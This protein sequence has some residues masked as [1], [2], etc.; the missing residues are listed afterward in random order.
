MKKKLGLLFILISIGA[1][2]ACSSIQFEPVTIDGFTISSATQHFIDQGIYDFDSIELATLL[3]D[4]NRE[5]P[6]QDFAF[7]LELV[8]VN[9][10]DETLAETDI[11]LPQ[12]DSIVITTAGTATFAPITFYNAGSYTFRI[13]QVQANIDAHWNTDITTFYL[14]VTV[15]EDEENNVLYAR[16]SQPEV[17]EF[18]N[19]FTLYVEE[20]LT[21]LFN[22]IPFRMSS[23]YALLINLSTGEV[24]FDYQADVRTYPASVTK[25]MTVLVGLAHGQMD[26]EVTVQADF[27]QLW[28]SQSAQAG[29]TYGET[30][31]F[32]EIIHGVMLMSGGEATETLAKHIAGSYEAF[33]DLMNLKAIELG[34]LDT[35]FVTATG[36]HDENHFT[37]AN[38]IAILLKYALEIPEFREMFILEEYELETPNAQRNTLRSTLFTTAP[39]LIFEGGEILGGRT[40]FTTP[41]GR[42]LASLATN[43]SEEF[44][45]ITFGAA[46]YDYDRTAHILD[47]LMIYEY[48]L[49]E[50]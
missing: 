45:L 34:M 6:D 32:S 25:L 21:T 31:T 43:G 16:I 13:Y 11:P 7:Y 30:R 29:F 19:D 37:T 8:N 44:I 5:V 46:A 35:H 17:M 36:L 39:T 10:A 49:Y 28:L 48:F 38:D 42:C 24:L 20:K 41:A 47:A 40:G 15:V 1:L 12:T 18:V 4:L 2:T 23:E 22:S 3:P 50:N 33:V 14:D 9:L 26:E 27:D